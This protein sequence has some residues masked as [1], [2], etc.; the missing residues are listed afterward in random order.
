MQKFKA[1]KNEKQS[2]QISDR[3]VE[4]AQIGKLQI[5]GTKC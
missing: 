2:Q 1:F 4:K 5:L 3:I